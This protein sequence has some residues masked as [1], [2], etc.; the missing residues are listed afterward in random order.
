MET[1]QGAQKMTSRYEYDDYPNTN[2]CQLLAGPRSCERPCECPWVAPTCS[3]LLPAGCH[4]LT[5]LQE[6]HHGSIQGSRTLMSLGQNTQSLLILY[7]ILCSP[8]HSST[9]PHKP[10]NGIDQHA[11]DNRQLPSATPHPILP[12]APHQ[13]AQRPKEARQIPPQHIVQPALLDR[14]PSAPA[15][16]PALTRLRIRRRAVEPPVFQDAHLGGRGHGVGRVCEGEVRLEVATQGGDFGGR[17]AGGEQT[18]EALGLGLGRGAAA[19][20]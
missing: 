9:P 10:K 2:H 17:E 5:T 14:K 3:I 4:I 20:A 18:V 11:H 1:D 19:A 13:R 6:N 7:P 8:S 16:V 15:R 12:K